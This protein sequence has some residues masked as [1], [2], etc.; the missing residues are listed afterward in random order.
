VFGQRIAR[1]K[2]E[3]QGRNAKA[4]RSLARKYGNDHSAIKKYLEK[5]NIKRQAKKNLSKSN[6]SAEKSD[7]IAVEAA[8]PKFICC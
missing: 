4:Y 3:K 2:A 5:M 7:Q 1:L 8:F 6:R